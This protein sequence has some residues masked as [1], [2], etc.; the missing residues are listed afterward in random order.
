M[1]FSTPLIATAVFQIS[2]M[3]NPGTF[4][5][6]HVYNSVWKA[7]GKHRE[8]AAVRG[9]FQIIAKQAP[10]QADLERF[11]QADPDNGLYAYL[12]LLIQLSQQDNPASASSDNHEEVLKKLRQLRFASPVKLYMKR[13]YEITESVFR[14]SHLS[15]RESACLANQITYT[16]SSYRPVLRKLANQLIQRGQQWQKTGHEQEAR[17]A[18]ATAV[19]LLTDIVDDSPKPEVALLAAESLP[20]ALKGLGQKQPADQVEDFQNRW[21]QLAGRDEVNLLPRTSGV[22]LASSH[23]HRTLRWLS[24]VLISIGAWLTLLVT[25]LVLLLIIAFTQIRSDE[26][27]NW[28]WKGRRAIASIFLACGPLIILLLMIA[29]VNMHFVWLFSIRSLPVLL[30]APGVSIVAA[31]LAGRFS[32]RRNDEVNQSYRRRIGLYVVVLLPVLT[33]ILG[34]L[35][36]PIGTEAWRPPAGI[37]LFRKLGFV[38]GAECCI[39]VVAWMIWA[40]IQHRRMII[41]LGTWA[42]ATFRVVVFSM[43]LVSLISLISLVINHKKD[44]IHQQAFAAAMADPLADRLGTDWHQV[45]FADAEK[46]VHTL[47]K[48]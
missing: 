35:M 30:V 34:V 16:F 10:S 40:L 12:D 24:A 3:V 8:I 29:T 44:L 27:L 33:L 11:R 36:I 26:Q 37:Q 38:I 42:R 45:Y 2:E 5:P 47:L 28:S 9:V 22:L 15:P 48:Q 20:V 14:K 18:Y 46:A 4:V 39:V 6:S 21:Q 1:C 31:G 19:R 32:I 25:G 17:L 43:L 23:H 7:I 13:Q 41:P